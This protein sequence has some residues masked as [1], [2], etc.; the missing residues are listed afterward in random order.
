GRGIDVDGIDH[1][2][3]YDLPTVPEDYVH[4][5]GRTARAGAT[6]DALSLVSPEDHPHVRGIEALIGQTIERRVVP[7][8]AEGGT[9]QRPG[10]RLAPQ[11]PARTPQRPPMPRPA[12]PRVWRPDAQLRGTAPTQ[13]VA[14][15]AQPAR[16]TGPIWRG[17]GAR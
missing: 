14:A 17:R 8:F 9:A 10:P 7:G 4:R 3:N 1:V 13:P 15:T 11:S 5:I 16:R 2:V 12:Q 6:G